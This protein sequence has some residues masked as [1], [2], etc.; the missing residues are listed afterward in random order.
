MEIL[1]ILM[2]ILFIEWIF[3]GIGY[4]VGLFLPKAPP[5]EPEYDTITIWID[6]D[7]D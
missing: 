3:Q 2:F 1:G 7:E 6:D 5:P 4:I